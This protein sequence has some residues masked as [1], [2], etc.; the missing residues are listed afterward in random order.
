MFVNGL[1]RT[2]GKGG[3]RRGQA[4]AVVCGNF[5]CH[6]AIFS[7]CGFPGFCCKYP[8]VTRRTIVQFVVIVSSPC[9]LSTF[10]GEFLGMVLRLIIPLTGGRVT[11]LS[12]RSYI[13][14]FCRVSILKIDPNSSIFKTTYVQNRLSDFSCRNT[15]NQGFRYCSD[16]RSSSFS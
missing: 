5:D 8:V 1:L 12:P 13:C 16:A 11:D 15:N 9:S 14:S 10:V 7:V 4:F 3:E 6:Y 2:P